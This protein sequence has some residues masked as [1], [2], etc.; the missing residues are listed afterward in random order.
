MDYRQKF[1]DFLTEMTDDLKRIMNET[2]GSGN[3]YQ[4]YKKALRALKDSP[5]AFP[6]A[7]SL[8]RLKGIG[9][10]IT[11]VLD[12]RSSSTSKYD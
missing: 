4:T 3:K 6:T 2:N 8:M 10:K 11:E 9:P 12:K 1:L 5:D 7:K